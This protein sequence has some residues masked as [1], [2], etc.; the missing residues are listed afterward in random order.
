M[1]GSLFVFFFFSSRRRHT[2]CA[3]VTGV[4]TCALPIWFKSAAQEALPQA[5]TVLDPFH[6]VRW[7]SNMLDE[8]RRRVQHDILGR[9]GRKNDP[10]YKSRRTLLTRI[11]S[12]SDANKKQLFQLFAD[13]H[14][15]EVDCTWSM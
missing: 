2:I 13:E 11:S 12:L 9:R 3:L 4:Q 15:L 14:H 6:V 8:C 10:L 1:F 5:Q 7:A